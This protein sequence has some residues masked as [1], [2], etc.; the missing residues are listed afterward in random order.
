M[1]GDNMKQREGVEIGLGC[2]HPYVKPGE[3]CELC[4]ETLPS[5]LQ[6]GLETTEEKTHE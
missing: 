1:F 4:G 6:D 3:R 2:G 5:S